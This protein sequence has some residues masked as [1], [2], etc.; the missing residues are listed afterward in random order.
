M[1]PLAPAGD[2]L[3]GPLPSVSMIAAITDCGTLV[4]A[5]AAWMIED[6]PRT[7][8]LAPFRFS[9]SLG[10]LGADPRAAGGGVPS[11]ALCSKLT[12]LNWPPVPPFLSA[13]SRID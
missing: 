3:L 2:V 13:P 4:D 8:S 11:S 12:A 7:R 10:V 6:W 1:K 9:A 5:E